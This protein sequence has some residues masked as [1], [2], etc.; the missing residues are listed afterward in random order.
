MLKTE[1]LE[2]QMLAK[3]EAGQKIESVDEMTEDYKTHLIN[4][5][6]MQADSELAGCYGYVP[7]IQKAPTIEEKFAV[8]N[9]VRDEMRHALAMYNLLE[10]LGVD[11]ESHIAKHDYTSRPT[12]AVSNIGD[13]RLA[14]DKRVNIF[15][16]PIDTWYD[17]IMF[18][19]CM[20]RGAGHQLEDVRQCS[21]GP[22][23]RE[24]EKIFKEEM[25]H[26]AH[27]NYWVKKLAENPETKPELQATLN[28]W[29][30]RTMNIFGRPGSRRN[31]LYQKYR[32]KLRDNDA[33]RQAFHDE[34]SGLCAQWGLTLPS[35]EAPWAQAGQTA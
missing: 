17:F 7:W 28:K 1:E 4:L 22:W 20:D 6:M 26:V 15:Y 27:G 32:L 5:M 23:S 18:N 10:R 11:I 25:V 30:L 8:S 2:A 33:V 19:F 31:A 9:I 13:Q 3:I 16:Y 12:D 21:Y 29:Y 35:W 34:V 24:I 14:D